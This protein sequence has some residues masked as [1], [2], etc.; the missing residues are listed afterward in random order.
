MTDEKT[1]TT[2]RIGDQE[3]E[4]PVLNLRAS[5]LAFKLIPRAYQTKDPDDLFDAFVRVLA[6]NLQVSQPTITA[7]FIN[8]NIQGASQISGLLTSMSEL[9]KKS[10]YEDTSGELSPMGAGVEAMLT[11]K[12]PSTESSSPSDERASREET[13]T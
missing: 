9:M 3:I 8:D 13:G 10:G 4:S 5:R 7:D 6:A 1:T 2:F 12:Q 11:L